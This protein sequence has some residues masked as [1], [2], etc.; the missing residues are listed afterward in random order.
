M[1]SSRPVPYAIEPDISRIGDG[2]PVP[3][4]GDA[5]QDDRRH[6]TTNAI[7][8]VEDPQRLEA[9]YE[10]LRVRKDHAH[11]ATRIERSGESG[12]LSEKRIPEDRRYAR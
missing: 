12:R 8:Q 9:E 5:L 11:R 3:S 6:G 1:K 10:H 4:G 7:E 2:N